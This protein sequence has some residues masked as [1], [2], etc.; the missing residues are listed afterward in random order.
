MSGPR[1]VTPYA[2]APGS[3]GAPIPGALLGFFLTGSSTKAATYSDVNLTIANTN[4]V[5]ANAAGIFPSIFLDPT[6]TYRVVESIPSDGVN[7]PVEVW[8]ADPV[9]AESS[10]TFG[11]IYVDELGAEIN[12]PAFDSYPAFALAL[13]GS[14]PVVRMQGGTYYLSQGI[15]IPPG[16]TLIGDSFLPGNP[17]VGTVIEFVLGVGTCVTLGGA[18]NG[19]A[20][21]YGFSITRAAGAIPA[22]SIG[23]LVALTYNSIL[24]NV[25]SFG[26]SIGF[27]FESDG[28]HGISCSPRGLY[29]G[30]ISDAHWVFD[31]WPEGKFTQCRLGQDGVG[32]LNCTAFIRIT[33]GGTGGAGPNTLYFNQ[34]V[35]VQAINGPSYAIQLV[36]LVDTGSN[37]VEFEFSQCHFEQ[38]TTA[39]IYADAS[40]S[41]FNRLNITDC[42]FNNPSVP[43]W[44]LDPAVEPADWSIHGNRCYVSTFDLA[45]NLPFGDVTISNNVISG[46][47]NITI[48]VGS[49][50]S[51]SDNTW[52]NL[53]TADGNLTIGGGGNISIIGDKL[54]GSAGTFINNCTGVV[55]V[56]SATMSGI[57]PWTPGLEFGGSSTGIAGAFVGDYEFLTRDLISIRFK[58]ILTNKGSQTGGAM[59]TGLPFEVNDLDGE[60]GS[61]VVA[62]AVNMASMT[63]PVMIWAQGEGTTLN[64]VQSSSAGSVA[65]TN[66]NFT[67]T[68]YLK[69]SL[70]Y[71]I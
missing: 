39:F 62:Q 40:V 41:Y 65:L 35:A 69:G 68:T 27:E 1:Y 3:T 46:A 26:H 53:S 56:Q 14:H 4:P 67:N 48:P 29:T 15:T 59:I 52:T 9:S 57:R 23:M 58:V 18:S 16:V 54:S 66:A 19:T 34:I 8:T 70:T 71:Q 11:G 36:D 20:G 43:M 47:G 25:G 10:A 12:N 61:G 49:T 22:G 24:E 32:D 51:L 5:V 33:G 6:I 28:V 2:Y 7:P 45:P 60:C 63:G 30:I 21:A 37:A 55:L 13:N 31:T 44:M 38:V 42:E 17:A 64:I 50:L